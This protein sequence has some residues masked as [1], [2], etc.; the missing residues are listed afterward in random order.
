MNLSESAFNLFVVAWIAIGLIAV[1]FEIRITAPYGR[2]ARAG[3]GPMVPARVG[4]MLMEGA[5]LVFF[6]VPF[7]MGANVKT[8][9]MWVFF[10]LWVVH[11]INRSII[12]P[13]RITSRPMPA[14]IM[15][16]GTV[17]GIVNGWLNGYWLGWLS[18]P[19]P[20]GWFAD[21]RFV[22]GVAL[23]LTGAAINLASDERL[24]RL[25]KPGGPEYTIPTGGLFR[26]VSCPNHLG[27]IVE[28]LGFAI[29]CWN[30]PALSFAVWTAANL[31]PRSLGH[32]R[33]YRE[34]FADY[35]RDRKAV[36]PFVL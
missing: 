24:M 26:W 14:A 15:G 22:V 5:S 13:L 16:M 28:W 4:W 7:L 31:I 10:A 20:D 23:F 12:F 25:R 3:W 34:R 32:H 29:L 27:E 1:P 17:F 35:P 6:A 2:H 9:P 21:P 19:Y 36:I 8:A 33:W 30:L 18:A 11:Y